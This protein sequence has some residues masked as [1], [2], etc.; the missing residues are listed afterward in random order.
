MKNATNHLTLEPMSDD[1]L[2][3]TASNYFSDLHHQIWFA[4]H[5][6]LDIFKK[7]RSLHM[8]NAIVQSAQG[9]EFRLRMSNTISLENLIEDYDSGCLS[10]QVDAALQNDTTFTLLLSGADQAVFGVKFIEENALQYIK[11]IIKYQ[12]KT[13][14]VV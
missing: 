7:S 3:I 4:D 2:S 5:P 11:N 14:N 1:E 12:G 13:D 10:E 9:M 8:R 6:I